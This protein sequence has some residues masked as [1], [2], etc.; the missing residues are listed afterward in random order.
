L[1]PL[2]TLI[3]L[4]TSGEAY[5]QL[6][7]LPNGLLAAV[8]GEAA[9]SLAFFALQVVVFIAMLRR[10]QR[11][12]QLFLF[13]WIALATVFLLDAAWISAVLGIPVNQ[14]LTG[15]VLVTPVVSFVL[16]GIWVA[17]VY[18]SVR[19]RNITRMDA[20]GQIASA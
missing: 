8:Y 15:N 5:R 6:M 19:V 12:K 9:L 13:Q 16:T 11:F 14:L 7:T 17:Y 2:R 3:E 18:K 10:S 20:A 4:G 1:A